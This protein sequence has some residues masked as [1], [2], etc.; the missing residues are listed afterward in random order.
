V[1]ILLALLKKD[2]FDTVCIKKLY[3]IY[4]TME[5]AL[6]STCRVNKYRH[7]HLHMDAVFAFL[8]E[9]GVFFYFLILKD[10]HLEIVTNVY[11]FASLF[12]L[13]FYIEV[14]SCVNRCKSDMCIVWKKENSL[15]IT[16]FSL[17]F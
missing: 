6:T 10:I 11:M 4:E 2:F 17:V 5:Y 15:Y 16:E 14:K 1:Y 3:L 12:R 13:K 9:R 7:I 8:L